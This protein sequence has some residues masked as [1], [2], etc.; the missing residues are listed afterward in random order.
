MHEEKMV[1]TPDGMELFHIK[2]IPEDPKA[3][4]VLVHGLSEH[5]GRY[6]YVVQ[7]LSN[8]G[9]GVYRF[10]NRGHGR[11]GEKRG[12]LDDFQKFIDDADLF[13]E[14]AM[15]RNTLENSTARFSPGRSSLN[16]PFLMR[17]K[18]WMWRM[19]RKP[20][21]PKSPFCPLFAYS[22]TPGSLT[23]SIPKGVAF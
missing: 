2:D 14:R 4:I 18:R 5:C 23:A 12:Y 10:D 13:V 22:E 3:T 17:S 7:K 11:S 19:H 8:F 16:C 20:P 15:E 9:Y 21:S 6:D 1:A